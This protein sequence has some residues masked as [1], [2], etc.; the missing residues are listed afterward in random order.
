MTSDT[1][2]VL[3]SYDRLKTGAMMR[4]A[5]EALR[6]LGH[7]SPAEVRQASEYATGLLCRNAERA[8][9]GS[10][11]LPL[12]ARIPEAAGQAVPVS[13]DGVVHLA[14]AAMELHC[15]GLR[16][17]SRPARWARLATFFNAAPAQSSSA[18]SASFASASSA[19]SARAAARHVS[20]PARARLRANVDCARVDADEVTPQVIASLATA[21]EQYQAAY[22]TGAYITGMARRSLATAYRRRQA[23]TDLMNA[24]ALAADDTRAQEAR[25][26]LDH[27]VTLVAR[28]L[29]A[30]YLL[31]QAESTP[32]AQERR[33][34]ATRALGEI[35]AVRAAR[36][37]QRGVASPDAAASHRREARA[38]LLLGEAAKARASLDF[39]RQLE[40]GPIDH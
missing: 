3:A 40:S 37:R 30:L 5:A 23:G 29:L 6:V 32:T 4:G 8:D 25:Y 21:L 19:F 27:P 38:L 10:S 20:V 11:G 36:N 22:G 28:S 9:W 15:A 34:L 39:A 2:A 31:A 35:T 1:G 26:G 13:H 24:I 12:P 16:P 7:R 18:S 17:A 33:D 14:E